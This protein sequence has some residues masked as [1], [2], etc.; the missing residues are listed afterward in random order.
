MIV[1]PQ[2]CSTLPR[3][4]GFGCLKCRPPP[5]R[6]VA[7]SDEPAA[8]YDGLA[9]SISGVSRTLTSQGPCSPWRR[10]LSSSSSPSSSSCSE[11]ASLGL[12]SCRHL[13][14]FRRPPQRGLSSPLLQPLL[15]RLLEA[16]R[17]DGL[18]LCRLPAAP[19]A[20]RVDTLSTITY[21]PVKKSSWNMAFRESLPLDT[22]ARACGG[23]FTSSARRLTADQVDW[24]RTIARCLGLRVGCE[25]TRG[26][27]T[28]PLSPRPCITPRKSRTAGAPTVFLW[29]LLCQY[30]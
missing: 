2:A 15:P 19:P 27:R 6:A 13:R 26:D 8:A 1:R 14:G 16:L 29:R 7:A 28:V 25:G 4:G 9:Q 30:T 12:G 22:N 10:G 24:G 11:S 5:G 17:A 23:T 20:P 3:S 21:R 18:A